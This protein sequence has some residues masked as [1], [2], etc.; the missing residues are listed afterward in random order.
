MKSQE[1]RKKSIFNGLLLLAFRCPHSVVSF[2]SRKV[3]GLKYFPKW[4]CKFQTKKSLSEKRFYKDSFKKKSRFQCLKSQ[5]IFST[6]NYIHGKLVIFG[7]VLSDVMAD[8][9]ISLWICLNHASF[10][11]V[12]SHTNCIMTGIRLHVSCTSIKFCQCI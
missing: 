7:V 6:S 9:A 11:S 2:F 5:H 10:T 4:L 3:Y 1:K 8:N 12:H